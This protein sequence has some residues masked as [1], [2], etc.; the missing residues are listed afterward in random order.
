MSGRAS[1]ELAM[2][3]AA[4]LSAAGEARDQ[5]PSAQVALAWVSPSLG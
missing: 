2:A 3:L 1:A 5:Q 4:S